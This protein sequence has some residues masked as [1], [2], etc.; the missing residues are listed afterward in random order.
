MIIES[1]ASGEPD[2]ARIRAYYDQTWLDYRALWLNPTNRAI[3]F[4]YWD[5]HTRNHAQS[6]I[7]MNRALAAKI[8]LRP[9]ERVLDA[10]CGVGGTA[11]WLAQTHGVQVVGIT[12]VAGQVARARR[13]ARE[14]GLE[15]QVAFEQQDYIR[16]TFAD[17]EFDVV[18]AQESLC[19]APDKRRFL[20]EAYRLLRPGGRLVVQEYLRFHR[21]YAE[22]D[23]RLLHRWHH[24]WAIPGLATGEELVTW[25]RQAGFGDVRLADI[26]ANVRPSLRRLYRLA[27]LVY[28]LHTALR[29]LRLRSEVQ[30]GN[31]RGARDQ[32]RT[33]RRRLWFVGILSATRP[34]DQ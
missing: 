6:L 28:P 4:G 22:G 15:G 25:T 13:Y 2:L 33:F 20:A 31:V 14:R 32:W 34:A 11:M 19:H 23:E 21:P 8:H 17:A 30:Q 3:H 1:P 5:A 10:G 26:S 7:D 29:L 27:A 24:G 16:T 18:W 9:G 12:P